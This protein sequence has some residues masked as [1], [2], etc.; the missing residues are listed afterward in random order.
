[1]SRITA[2]NHNLDFV[3]MGRKIQKPTRPH[4]GN[5]RYS[6]QRLWYRPGG[7]HSV[8]RQSRLFIFIFIF[9]VQGLTVTTSHLLQLF[10]I[11]PVFLRLRMHAVYWWRHMVGRRSICWSLVKCRVL[12][13]SPIGKNVAG[14]VP[15]GRDFSPYFRGGTWGGFFFWQVLTAPRSERRPREPPEQPTCGVGIWSK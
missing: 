14:F 3:L 5:A 9:I 6:Y 2:T 4:P 1:M 7:A 15:A 8:R 12:R 13:S 10:F 11:F